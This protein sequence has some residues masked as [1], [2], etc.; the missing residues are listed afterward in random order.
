MIQGPEGLMHAADMHVD[1]ECTF[2]LASMLCTNISRYR[3]S[4]TPVVTF[5]TMYMHR[6]T[7]VLL[8]QARTNLSSTSASISQLYSLVDQA[9]AATNAQLAATTAILQQHASNMTPVDDTPVEP[10][11]GQ[12]E[13][14]AMV[15]AETADA[16]ELERNIAAAEVGGASSRDL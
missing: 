15:E 16:K 12:V 11:R 13:A 5:Q 2:H 1:S 4:R 6:E 10:G 7:H 9:T 8:L 3:H 14:Q